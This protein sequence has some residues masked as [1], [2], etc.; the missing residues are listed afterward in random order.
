MAAQKAEL[1][2]K[3]IRN[4][5]RAKKREIN[6]PQIHLGI[7]LGKDNEDELHSP[8]RVALK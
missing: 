3:N 5:A 6:Y 1:T 8:N 2:Y 7:V 4:L